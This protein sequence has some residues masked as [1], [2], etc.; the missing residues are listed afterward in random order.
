[1]TLRLSSSIL[2]DCKFSFPH[3]LL[4]TDRETSNL[5][6][7]LPKYLSTDVKLSKAQIFWIVQSRGFLGKPIVPLLKIDLPLVKNVV[8]QA[9]SVLILLGLR[10]AALE[11][12]AG[13]LKNILRSGTHD[14]KIFGSKTPTLKIWDEDMQDVIKIKKSFKDS[15]ILLEA[16]KLDNWK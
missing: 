13:I 10:N 9:E 11:V 14:S 15:G 12:D 1:M 16:A 2:D 5:C 7:A 8:I 4:I 3:K 6:K